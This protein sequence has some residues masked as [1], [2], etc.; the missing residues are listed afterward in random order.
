[1]KKLIACLS[2]LSVCFGSSVHA[3]GLI[4]IATQDTADLQ[5]L[6]FADVS[7]AG[8][9]ITATPPV[10]ISAPQPTG[11]GVVFAIPN[12]GN[13]DEV[14]YGANQDVPNQDGALHR[15][16]D[17]AGHLDKNQRHLDCRPGNRDGCTR[18]P[19]ARK[20]FMTVRTL[21]DGTMD[22]Y[23]VFNQQPRRC[24]QAEPQSAAGR[25]VGE[26]ADY[27]GLYESRLRVPR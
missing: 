2:I 9:S 20:C 17:R 12:F 18:V 6:Y 25:E 27:A 7:G 21:S 24:D 26:F 22:L 10:K 8:G 13:P 1:M 3:D 16:T 14:L 15:R 4:Y 23:V 5:E 19:T 11:G